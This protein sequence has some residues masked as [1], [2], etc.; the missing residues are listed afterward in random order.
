MAE[1]AVTV[2]FAGFVTVYLEGDDEVDEEMLIQTAIEQASERLTV[3]AD[4]SITD[5]IPHIEIGEWD[6]FEH[7][8]SGNVTWVPINDAFVES[9]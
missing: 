7:V 6:L 4:N 5:E 3:R 1:Y 2:P 9:A 8:A